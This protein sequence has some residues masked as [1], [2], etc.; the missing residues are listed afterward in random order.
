[1]APQAAHAIPSCLGFDSNGSTGV[2]TCE[3]PPGITI[4]RV[5]V[6]PEGVPTPLPRVLPSTGTN[7]VLFAWVLFLTGL[8]GLMVRISRRSRTGLGHERS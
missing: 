4:L 2:M 3:V 8:G 5:V 6:S 7:M 1:M